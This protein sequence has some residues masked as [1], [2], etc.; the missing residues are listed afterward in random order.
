[1]EKVIMIPEWQYNRMLE[2]YDKVVQE[3]EELKKS[4]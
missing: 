2:S 1:M 3:Q 4:S